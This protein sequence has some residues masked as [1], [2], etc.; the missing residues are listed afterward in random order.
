VNG[1][2]KFELIEYF[3]DGMT[4]EDFAKL[5][6]IGELYFQR[7]GMIMKTK[8]RM[9]C[10]NCSHWNRIGVEKVFSEQETPEAK[11]KAFIPLCLPLKTEKCSK[12][13]QVIAE[14]KEL[15]RI[16]LKFA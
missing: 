6:G 4:I 8:L 12:C 7:L 3:P 14:A 1:E 13:G 16:S 9:K 5:Y 11:V 2:G 10:P 15:I